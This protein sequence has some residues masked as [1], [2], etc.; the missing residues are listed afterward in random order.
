MADKDP[1]VQA[2]VAEALASLG[3]AALPKAD[4]GP[5]KR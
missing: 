3:D 4:Q 2:N 1:V 5:A